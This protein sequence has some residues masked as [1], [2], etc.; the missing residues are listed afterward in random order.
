MALLFTAMLSASSAI[1]LY[2]GDRHN[3]GR[4]IR[5]TEAAIDAEKRLFTHLREDE[6]GYAELA[7]LIASRTESDPGSFYLL[8]D[9]GG[10][11][12]AGNI[13]IS[14]DDIGRLREGLLILHS[15]AGDGEENS[16]TVAVKAALFPD[17]ATLAI[18]RDVGDIVAAHERARLL[19]F[20]AL[21]L[22]LCVVAVSYGISVFVV[23]RINV[24][25]QTARDI[26]FT[27]DLSRRI[28]V[29][30]RWDDLSELSYV[31]DLMF[32]RLEKTVNG[33]REVS[34]NIA[35]DLRTPLTRLRHMAEE[36]CLSGDGDPRA[37]RIMAEADKLLDTFNAVMRISRLEKESCGGAYNQHID[38]S[39]LA[40]DA[41]DMYMPLAEEKRIALTVETAP[42]AVKGDRDLLFQ[43]CVNILD[44]AIK[45]TPEGGKVTVR[46][47][48]ARSPGRVFIEAEDNGPGLEDT[49]KT[50]VTERFYRA[51]KS[52]HLSG[53]GLGLSLA[54]AAAER[55]GGG[56][57]LYDADPYGL[58]VRI[59][60]P[61]A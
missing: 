7:R 47:G 55:H 26:I 32:G 38:L 51:E 9:A 40:E 23:R 58:R 42:A 10:K 27:G 30:S 45:F 60:L 29:D 37:A 8:R 59:A 19:G 14:P 46:S 31:L 17:G 53:N 16:I 5:E 25:V 54:R 11:R 24:I 1:V 3:D 20:I 28:N 13:T 33:V 41:A 61:A 50:K 57:Y 44:N 6:A 36:L 49:E 48:A 43:A 35:H 21:G 52:R 15:R 34:D 39:A 18:G 4:V 2:L 22:M 56:L 12:I